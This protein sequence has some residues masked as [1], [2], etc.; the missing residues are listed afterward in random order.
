MRKSVTNFYNVDDMK[1]LVKN[2]L[3]EE[4][5]ATKDDLKNF[6]TKDDLKNF[7]TKDDLK[8]FAT[9]DD[10]KQE[11]SKYATKDDL[12]G[13]KDTILHELQAIRDNQELITDYK[14]QIEN[15]DVRIEHIEKHLHLAQPE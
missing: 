15:H 7:A 5:V 9:K 6:A 11:F 1:K 8:N 4:K 12:I 13:F 3:K 10:L 2:V 14:D